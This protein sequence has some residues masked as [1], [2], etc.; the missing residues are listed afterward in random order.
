VTDAGAADYI[1][2]AARV[3]SDLMLAV[4][5]SNSPGLSVTLMP[6]IDATRNLYEVAYNDVE[7]AAGDVLARGEAAHGAL[8]YALDVA[9]LAVCAEMVGGMQWVMDTTVEYA[10]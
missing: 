4:V 7:V 6:S 9:T 3:G 5:K 10:K 2:T 1:I 8:E